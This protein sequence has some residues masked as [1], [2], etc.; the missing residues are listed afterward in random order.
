MNLET[1]KDV[2]WVISMIFFLLLIVGIII[3]CFDDGRTIGFRVVNATC[4]AECGGFI[5]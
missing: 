1:V 2:I 4:A 3:A 5:P